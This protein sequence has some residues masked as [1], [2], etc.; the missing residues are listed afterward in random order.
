MTRPPDEYGDVLR[1]ALRAEA[2][3]VVPSPDGLEIIRARIERR[4][5]RNLFWWRAGA[6]AASAVLVAG[7][8]VMA[9]PQL[10]SQIIDQT[11]ATWVDNE[12]TSKVPSN[13]ST[14][15]SQQQPSKGPQP[16]P[17][18]VGVPPVTRTQS[19]RPARTAD[20][21]SRP[22]PSPTSTSLPSASP[23]PTEC[24]TAVPEET[25]PSEPPQPPTDC[26]TALLTPSPS[27]TLLEPTTQPSPCPP[28]ECPPAGATASPS[29]MAS[30][31]MDVANV[32]S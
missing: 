9:V 8:I 21:T 31:L 23:S 6:A 4:G 7:T 13:S 1:R 30:P 17:S 24:P 28:D 32:P 10:R 11:P 2:D 5:V 19:P 25:V 3:A 27:P 15:R 14:T 26:P 20:S 18:H 12:T 22:S 29:T 16:E